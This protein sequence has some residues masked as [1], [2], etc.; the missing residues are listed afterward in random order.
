[1]RFFIEAFKQT[2]P[3]IV[4]YI[5]VGLAYGVLAQKMGLSSLNTL[6]MSLLVFAGSSQLIAVGLMGAGMP[7][8]SVIATTF[9]VNLRHMPMSAALSPWLK[10][11]NKQ[12]LALFSFQLTDETFALQSTRF[13]R[14]ELDK[15]T[16]FCVNMIAHFSWVMGTLL[17]IVASSLIPDVKPVGLDYAL[18][19]MFMAL[20]VLQIR[21][22]MHVVVALAAGLLSVGLALG[23]LERVHVIVATLCAASLGVGV[24]QWIKR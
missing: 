21:E 9:V 2:S 8:F 15:G 4:G 13:A 1:M 11:W 3:I 22:R 16:T 23:G 5:P 6:A 19:A 12:E 24:E 18:P 7:A 17:G 20:L 10:D 14:G